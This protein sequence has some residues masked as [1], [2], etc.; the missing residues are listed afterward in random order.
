MLQLEWEVHKTCL[1]LRARHRLGLALLLRRAKL[2]VQRAVHALR[3]AQLLLQVR[4]L[5]TGR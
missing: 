1:Q 2:G 5:R 3:R 4:H